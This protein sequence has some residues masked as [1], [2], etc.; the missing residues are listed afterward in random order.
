MKR[1]VADR[2]RRVQ[3]PLLAT[4]HLPIRE[5]VLVFMTI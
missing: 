2:F 4:E 3:I 5:N 1:T